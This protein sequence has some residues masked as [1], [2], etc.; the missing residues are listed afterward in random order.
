MRLCGGCSRGQSLM[1]SDSPAAR[2]CVSEWESS[3]SHNSSAVSLFFYDV[4][5]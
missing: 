2:V 5:V 3:S 1:C 4:S